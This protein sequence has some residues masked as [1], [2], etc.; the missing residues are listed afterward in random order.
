MTELTST[1]LVVGETYTRDGLR[2]LFGITD[3]TLNNGIFRPKNTRSV[4]LFV[5]EEKTPDRV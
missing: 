3:A 1:Q 2:E 4:W 5:T